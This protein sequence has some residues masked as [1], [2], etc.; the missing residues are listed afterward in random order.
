MTDQEMLQQVQER[1]AEEQQ[2]QP[3]NDG[4]KLD[5]H[6]LP[7]PK[8]DFV[9]RCLYANE[10][11]DGLL[12]SYLFKGRHAYVGQ[13]D[14]WI[15]WS[16]H[17]WSVDLIEKGHRA[18]ADVEHV[19]QAYYTTG[20]HFDRLAKD[21]E[22]DGD[23]ESA[24]RLKAKA[25]KMKARAARLRTE[26]G[27]KRCLEFAKTNLESPLA[28]AGDEVDRD[29]W[30]LPM[31][32]GVVDLRTGEMRPGRP[33]DWLVKS[34]PV[35]WQGIDALAL[36]GSASSPRSWAMTRRWRPSSSAPSAMASP[37]WPASTSSWCCSGV[38]A[39]ARAS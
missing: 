12:F 5:K 28:I 20:A 39:T 36:T 8:P 23:K 21:A 15:W 27:R 14:E 3:S 4:P 29:P 33:D 1:I 24:G 13:A 26:T 25:E 10:L 18:R 35:E 7:I 38:D 16:G 17:H 19:A 37:V 2:G 11:G 34:S 32:N 9:E 30:S 6:G 22:R 31:A